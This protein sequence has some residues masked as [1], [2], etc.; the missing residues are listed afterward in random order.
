MSSPNSRRVADT[1]AEKVG[2]TTFMVKRCRNCAALLSPLAGTCTSC[3]STTLEWV[4]SCGQG[5]IVSWRVVYRVLPERSLE[6]W[7]PSQIAI[8]ALDEGPW[9]YTTIEGEI[10]PS[11]DK[12]VRVRFEPG[13]SRGGFPVFATTATS[14]RVPDN[15]LPGRM[16]AYQ[17]SR[18]RHG[19]L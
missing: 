12:P 3:K 14:R 13:P 7:A 9:V 19:L 18:S 4:P 10:P 1:T 5:A 6:E 11:S 17:P 8:V 2:E 16:S 15:L